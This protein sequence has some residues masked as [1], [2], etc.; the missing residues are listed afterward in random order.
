MSTEERGDG[1]VLSMGATMGGSG[2]TLAQFYATGHKGVWLSPM[3]APTA[4]PVIKSSPAPFNFKLA[5][6]EPVANSL[7]VGPVA[8]GMTFNPVAYM[9]EQPDWCLRF[10]QLAALYELDEA[11]YEA[12]RRIAIEVAKEGE[13]SVRSLVAAWRRDA[14][15]VE[16]AD[17]VAKS[18]L[19][20]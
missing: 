11:R 9:G 5:A 8:R 7:V 14:A 15:L 18:M 10:M 19:P 2:K 4:D 1:K 16:W 3:A 12:A 6:G 13:P 17:A 20:A